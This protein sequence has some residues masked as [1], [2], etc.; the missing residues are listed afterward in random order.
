[1]VPGKLV[2]FK[3]PNT[4]PSGTFSGFLSTT[5]VTDSTGQATVLG[6]T[7]NSTVG[8]PYNVIASIGAV[9]GNF[10]LT[11]L[12]PVPQAAV[13]IVPTHVALAG[14]G[15]TPAFQVNVTNTGIIPTSG[16]LTVTDTLSSGLAFTGQ[17]LAG[18][19]KNGWVCSLS[20]QVVTCS[21]SNPIAV[22]SL[23]SVALYVAVTAPSGTVLTD[24]AVLTP[25]DPTPQDNTATAQVVAGKF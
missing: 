25:T 2:T 20:G 16:T 1:V 19:D 9:S 10:A 8:G 7:A 6:F 15:T 23:N 4:G 14:G 13:S 24:T 5:A 21:Y 12:P 18:A 11:N 3:A 17:T 22:G